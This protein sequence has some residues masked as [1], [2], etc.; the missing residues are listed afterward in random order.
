S[1]C[2]RLWYKDVLRSAS[3]R[4]D[5]ILRTIVPHLDIKDI[6][7]CNTC[8]QSVNKNSIPV[9]ASYNGFKFPTKPDYLP[10]L[11]LV[12][13]RLISPRIP[14]MQIRRLRHVNGQYGIY[15]QI[16]NV[17]VSIDS[18]VQQIENDDYVNKLHYLEKVTLINED[19]VTCAIYFNKLVNVLLNIL[20]SLKK[21]PFGK[22]YVMHYFKRIEFQ[23]RGSPHAHTLL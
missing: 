9:M 1:V 23:H 2:K 3:L 8:A 16:I 11:D 21:S 13:E 19:S 15:G 18:M 5:T 22:Y 10:P 14:F 12:S 6:V 4:H 17:P 7:L 20:Q